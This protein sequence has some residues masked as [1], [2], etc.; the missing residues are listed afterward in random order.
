MITIGQKLYA[1][2]RRNRDKIF[3]VASEVYSKALRPA[4]R[5]TLCKREIIF[6][7]NTNVLLLLLLLLQRRLLT[8]PPPPTT[9]TT[10]TITT[11]TTTNNNNNIVRYLDNN[12]VM[13]HGPNSSL[14][15]L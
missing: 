2:R 14:I 1:L 11:T 12:N 10:T 4:V 8:T 5:G 13:Y 3:S 7:C 9:T 15:Q 6:L